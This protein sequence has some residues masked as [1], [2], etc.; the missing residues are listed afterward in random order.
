M[1]E[2]PCADCSQ[3]KVHPLI[4]Q[5]H[6]YQSTNHI[7]TN[8][9]TTFPPI[10]QSHFQYP[11]KH[12]RWFQR[13]NTVKFCDTKPANHMWIL[14]LNWN[15][16]MDPHQYLTERF[17]VEF[18]LPALMAVNSHCRAICEFTI[19]LLITSLSTALKISHT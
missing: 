13:A 10:D 1:Q 5:S 15:T 7:P 4:G 14:E 2:V 16:R 18:K 12:P 9:P 17:G 11:Q 19:T 6:F 8:R 3:L